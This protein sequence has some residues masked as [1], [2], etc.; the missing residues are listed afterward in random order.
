[1]AVRFT[2]PRFGSAVEIG[3]RSILGFGGKSPHAPCLCQS[4]ASLDAIVIALC[5]QRVNSTS[6]VCQKDL[7]YFN[8]GSF[9]PRVAGGPVTNG[10]RCS[11]KWLKIRPQWRGLQQSV[12]DIRNFAIIYCLMVPQGR[13]LLTC[14]AMQVERGGT[15]LDSVIN[16]RQRLS[17][18]LAVHFVALSG[19]G[20]RKLC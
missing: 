10:Y 3:R 14:V 6:E 12:A 1:M 7:P 17:W 16:I 20:Y 9:V 4:V 2:S 11:T 8:D 18:R 15:N 19:S 13:V 5:Q